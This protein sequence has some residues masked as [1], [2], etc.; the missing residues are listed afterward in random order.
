[1]LSNLTQG[2]YLSISFGWGI[3]VMC[4]VYVAGGISGAHLN[5]AVRIAA[6]IFGYPSSI[7]TYRSGYWFY[8]AALGPIVGG[9]LGCF[10][11]DLLIFNGP[12]SPLN[13]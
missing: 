10:L 8:T 9:L 6:S 4:G 7:W 12:A 5:P 13:R 1:V 11:Y 2:S 3:G